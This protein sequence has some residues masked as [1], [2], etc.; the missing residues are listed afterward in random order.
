[1]TDHNRAGRARSGRRAVWIFG[2]VL[3]VLHWDFWLWDDATL[4]FG[5]LPIGLAY[6]AVFSVLC[7]VVWAL[8]VKFAWPEHIERWAEETSEVS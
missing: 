3:G 5:F 6:H 4:L 7:G 8:A 2:L 1:V